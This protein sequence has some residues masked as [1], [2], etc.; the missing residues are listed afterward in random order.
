MPAACDEPHTL[1]LLAE[2]ELLVV[3]LE[4]EGWPIFRLPYL[5]SVHSSAVTTC[6]HVSNVPSQLWQKLVDVGNS[7][8]KKASTRVSYVSPVVEGSTAGS[9]FIATLLSASRHSA[10]RLRLF[11][12]E[13][14]S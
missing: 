9:C 10:M 6:Q 2:E 5:Y 3:D 7:Q 8:C 4:S 1:V 11:L 13:Q 14:V 12:D